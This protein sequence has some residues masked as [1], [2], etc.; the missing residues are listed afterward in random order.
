MLVS[1][2]VTAP[3]TIFIYHSRAIERVYSR[4]VLD[5]VGFGC[6]DDFRS[7]SVGGEPERCDWPGK[8]N[9]DKMDFAFWAPFTLMKGMNKGCSKDEKW[10]TEGVT[11][12]GEEGSHCR[13]VSKVDVRRM[14]NG[15]RRGLFICG[16]GDVLGLRFWGEQGERGLQGELLS[17]VRHRHRHPSSRTRV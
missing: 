7:A 1:K 5:G 4:K 14:I 16:M 2:T 17:L 6:S 11:V 8:S 12:F 3:N 9:E 10:V 13:G 15:R